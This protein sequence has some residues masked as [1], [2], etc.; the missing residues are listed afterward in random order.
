MED[1]RGLLGESW[2]PSD[3]EYGEEGM[4]E[5]GGGGDDIFSAFFG[6]GGGR[7]RR[8]TAERRKGEN[9][10]KAIPVTLEDL[11]NGSTLKLKVTKDTVCF[12]CKG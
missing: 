5:G 3:D 2:M 7:Q 9:A 4:R 1:A 11:Y 8:K 10:M 12:T 6:G